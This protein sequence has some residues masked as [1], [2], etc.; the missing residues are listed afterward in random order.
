[1]GVAMKTLEEIV[2]EVFGEIRRSARARGNVE[3][4]G[5]VAPIELGK[6]RAAISHHDAPHEDA[7]DAFGGAR[8]ERRSGSLEGLR[9]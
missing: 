8:I 6:R 9:A 3:K 4:Q 1:M 7:V 2:D 5:G